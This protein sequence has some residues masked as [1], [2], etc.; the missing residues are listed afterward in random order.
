[1]ENY[2][3]H[4]AAGIFSDEIFSILDD[5]A[6]WLWMS[7]SKGVF[8]ANKQELNDYA[9]HRA[10][11]VGEYRLRQDRWDGNPAMQWHRQ[12]G[13]VA[14]SRQRLWFA[15]SKGVVEVD[16]DTVRIDRKPPPVT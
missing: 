15:T 9:V 7:C 14:G 12:P 13:Q 10:A 6:G 1:M 3:L 16:P 5:D 4:H 2:I 11:S 8:R